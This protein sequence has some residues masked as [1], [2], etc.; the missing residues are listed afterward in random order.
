MRALPLPCLAI[1]AAAIAPAAPAA[2]QTQA[3][4]TTAA[5]GEFS[6]ADAALNTTYRALLARLTPGGQTR[7]RA[8]QRAWIPARDATCAFVAGGSQNSGS[9]GPMVMAGCLAAE[10][11]ARTARLAGFVTCAEGDVACPR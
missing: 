8:A 11:R 10:T 7:L 4:M 6:A 2:A 1:A 9:V 3:A 5:S